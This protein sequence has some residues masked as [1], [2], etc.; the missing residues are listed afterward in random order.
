VVWGDRDAY[1]PIHLVAGPLA[2]LLA[3][4]LDIL[5]GCHFL[6]IDNPAALA[7]ALVE[8]L[9]TLSV[10]DDAPRR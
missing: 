8:F 6:P 7:T 1:Q 10:E 2:E 3:A 9:A 4:R 5:P